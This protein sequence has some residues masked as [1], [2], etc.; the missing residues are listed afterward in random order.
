MTFHYLNQKDFRKTIE[1]VSKW[2]VRG[3]CLLFIVVHPLRFVSN[4]SEYFSNKAKIEKTPWRTKIEYHPKKF[5]DYVNTAINSSFN[6]VA[7][8][9]PT[10]ISEEAKNN[11][12]EYKKYSSI[13]TRLLIKAIKK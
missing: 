5:S 6:L 3:G 13:P 10:P 11:P 9:E 1:N 2:L 8:E 7:V 12:M 4:H